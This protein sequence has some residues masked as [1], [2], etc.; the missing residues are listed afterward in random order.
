MREWERWVVTE[1]GED[2]RDG[3]RREEEMGERRR[4]G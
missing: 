4:E 2:E 3:G 1:R